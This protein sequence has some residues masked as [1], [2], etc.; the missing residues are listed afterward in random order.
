AGALHG[1]VDG[2]VQHGAF[3]TAA[4][5]T[6]P[7][8]PRSIP[9]I[10]RRLRGHW[11]SVEWHV[12]TALVLVDLRYIGERRNAPRMRRVE[13]VGGDPRHRLRLGVEQRCVWLSARFAIFAISVCKPTFTMLP[14]WG[15]G[16][17]VKLVALR[18]G[19]RFGEAT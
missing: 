18:L 13:R 14:S 10:V 15:G 11:R 4:L 9:R 19:G 1:G 3:C 7:P 8:I 6:Q 5:I 2:G 12:F 16:A 17:I